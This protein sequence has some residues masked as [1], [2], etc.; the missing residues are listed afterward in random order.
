MKKPKRY[1][2]NYTAAENRV[3]RDLKGQGWTNREIA[4]HMDRTE[5]G[6]SR[7]WSNINKCGP[8]FRKRSLL[9]EKDMKLII[10]TM[11]ETCHSMGFAKPFVNIWDDRKKR[12]E[13]SAK[14]NGGN[15]WPDQVWI[16][17]KKAVQKLGYDCYLA[18]KLNHETG[19]EA[20][21]RGLR[22]KL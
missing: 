19:E 2:K 14:V 21:S 16:N 5:I 13:Y 1:D 3:I 11:R 20:H 8:V 7:H 17:C 6:I 4:E 15:R 12:N 10:N 9:T 22:I 18:S